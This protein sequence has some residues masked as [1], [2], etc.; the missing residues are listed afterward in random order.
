[1][2]VGY[3]QVRLMLG[4]GAVVVIP[5]VFSSV[6]VTLGKG[7]ARDATTNQLQSY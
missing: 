7:G 6:L 5:D 2:L 1:M 3:V 4:V